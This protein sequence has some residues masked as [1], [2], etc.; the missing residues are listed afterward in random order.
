MSKWTEQE[1]TEVECEALRVVRMCSWGGRKVRGQPWEGGRAGGVLG[2][3]KVGF[4]WWT[5]TDSVRKPNW[6]RKE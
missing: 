6:R 4:R 3:K 5:K 1:E 2:C